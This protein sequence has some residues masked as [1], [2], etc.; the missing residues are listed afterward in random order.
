MPF[1]N[2]IGFKKMNNINPRMPATTMLLIVHSI[3]IKITKP[4][5]RELSF[6]SIRD[7]GKYRP[8]IMEL[9]PGDL[10]S[11]RAKGCR[12]KTEISLNHCMALS[13]II[14]ANQLYKEA[15]DN[16][17][18]GKRK[19]KPKKAQFPYSSVYYKALK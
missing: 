2:F 5:K 19:R 14:Y 10:I 6:V 9:I 15:I 16:Y 1:F 12:R 18:A 11:F 3:M 4:I 7:K 13:E 17:K 8:V